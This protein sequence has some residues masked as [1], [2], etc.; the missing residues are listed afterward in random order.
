MK[1]RLFWRLFVVLSL[2]G[3]GF[4]SLL[5]SAAI[6]SDEK[7]SFIAEEHQQEILNWG[8]QA[9]SLFN[10]GDQQALDTWIKQ[11]SERENTWA[12]VVKTQ[13]NV[14]AG[15]D[16]NERFLSLIHI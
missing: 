9:Q 11:L 2:G 4:F 12:T 13:V 1:K 10:Q 6:L 8:A 14:L 16:L 3:V 7:M 5:H 15:D